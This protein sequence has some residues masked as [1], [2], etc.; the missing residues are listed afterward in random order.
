MKYIRIPEIGWNMVPEWV[1]QVC[2]KWFV[3][4]FKP[5][6]TH[7]LVYTPPPLTPPIPNWW[8]PENTTPE[9]T[10]QRRKESSLKPNPTAP[11]LK[12]D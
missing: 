6:W 7:A 2:S 10:P 8:N 12:A 11:K 9:N 5:Y 3:H 1:L 4:G